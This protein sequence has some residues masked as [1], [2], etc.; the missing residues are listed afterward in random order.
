MLDRASRYSPF[1]G[2]FCGTRKQKRR[3]PIELYIA[4]TYSYAHIEVLVTF[5]LVNIFGFWGMARYHTMRFWRKLEEIVLLA[6][7][8]LLNQN[9]RD[10]TAGK[11]AKNRTDMFEKKNEQN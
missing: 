6:S 11:P 2:V 4:A 7:Q 3:E 8:T 9:F 10:Q 1:S 5:L